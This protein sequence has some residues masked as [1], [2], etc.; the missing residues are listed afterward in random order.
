M[1]LSCGEVEGEVVQVCEEIGVCF[2][3]GEFVGIVSDIFE[4]CVEIARCPKDLIIE[5][6][7]EEW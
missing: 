4:D 3:D 7:G 2:A 6:I 1:C 5:A